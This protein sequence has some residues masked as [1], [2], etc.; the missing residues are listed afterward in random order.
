MCHF[1]RSVMWHDQDLLVDGGDASQS[2]RLVFC[3]QSPDMTDCYGTRIHE[4]LPVQ[5]NVYLFPP[6]GDL[7]NQQWILSLNVVKC[8]S[9]YQ[10]HAP[11]VLPTNDALKELGDMR[12]IS[13]PRS[14]P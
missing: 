7:N 2:E 4:T 8:D 5:G 12:W 10:V 9:V 6:G 3:D 13:P 1:V 14:R 11:V